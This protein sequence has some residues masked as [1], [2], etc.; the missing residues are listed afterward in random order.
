MF[1]IVGSDCAAEEGDEH[2]PSH[3]PLQEGFMDYGNPLDPTG[4]A[5]WGDESF[6]PS[7]GNGRR[8]ESEEFY[9]MTKVASRHK[10]TQRGHS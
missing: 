3:D 8:Y 7:Y 9:G 10:G 6:G 5:K 4:E 1:F 2:T